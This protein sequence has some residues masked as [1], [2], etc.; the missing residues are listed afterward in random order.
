MSKVLDDTAK[1]KRKPE[2]YKNL[3]FLYSG[4]VCIQFPETKIILEFCLVHRFFSIVIL[5]PVTSLLTN[6]RA[7][8]CGR[9]YIRRT[10]RSFSLFHPARFSRR[11]FSHHS[12]P[13]SL[14]PGD[15]KTLFKKLNPV[16]KIA[17]DQEK[18]NKN[19]RI[20]DLTCLKLKQF[21]SIKMDCI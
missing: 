3:C 17:L 4:I 20:Y 7:K 5:L 9:K 10:K 12:P 13:R 14:F 2:N 15:I 6:S 18:E 1:R 11:C 19:Q 21:P 16:S 8:A